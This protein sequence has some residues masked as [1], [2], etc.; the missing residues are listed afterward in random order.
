MVRPSRGPEAEAAAAAQMRSLFPSDPAA[1]AR[2]TLFGAQR[3]GSGR[4]NFSRNSGLVHFIRG[5]VSSADSAD[6][7]TAGVAQKR[8]IKPSVVAEVGFVVEELTAQL[9]VSGTL[10]QPA[11]TAL[12]C[13]CRVW[14]TPL[15]PY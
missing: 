13:C 2:P 15:P 9:L 10:C 12:P 11:P 1:A 8:Q 5:L 4:P 14:A 7:A 6:A 3:D